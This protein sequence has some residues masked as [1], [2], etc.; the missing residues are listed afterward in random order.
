MRIKYWAAA[1]IFTFTY[2]LNMSQH[3]GQWDRYERLGQLQK[4]YEDPR[5]PAFVHFT[6]KYPCP[7]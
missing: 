7:E 6:E 5:V 4:G 2:R 3:G 1:R